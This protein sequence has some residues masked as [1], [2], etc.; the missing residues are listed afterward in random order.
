AAT[1]AGSGF[2]F[3]PDHSG[4]RST[5]ATAELNVPVYGGA[6]PSGTVYLSDDRGART[7]DPVSSGTPAPPVTGPPTG[8]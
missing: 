1:A 8:R 4:A 5:S 2:G 3:N 7:I 6:N